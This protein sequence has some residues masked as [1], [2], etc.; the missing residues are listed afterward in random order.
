VR[1]YFTLIALPVMILCLSGLSAFA[2]RAQDVEWCNGK[3]DASPDLQIGACTAL[4]QSGKGNRKALVMWFNNRGL[5]FLKK[6]NFDAAIADLEQSL[7][8]EPDNVIAYA[9]RAYLYCSRKD[10]DKCISDNTKVISLYAPG[11]P[12]D[13]KKQAPYY[14]SRAEAYEA[15]GN[16]DLALSDL[17]E[18]IK[19][20]STYAGYFFHRGNIFQEKSDYDHAIADFTDAIRLDPKYTGA[21]GYRA[22][23][24]LAKGDYAQAIADSSEAI[25]VAPIYAIA[26][27]TRCWARAIL[28]QL[29]DALKDCNEALDDSSNFFGAFDSR[30]LVY[31]KLGEL[32]KSIT[33]YNSALSINPKFASSLY[34]RGLAKNKKQSGSGDADIAAAVELS[35]DIA[36]DYDSYGIK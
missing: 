9:T 1:S 12:A 23:A 3:G 24:Y 32:D 30:A 11:P 6:S 7:R 22:I 33:D 15:T 4:I 16:L 36:K 18:A 10:Y 27:N 26:W 5:A 14:E 35:P 8:I 28:G 2:Q 31:L 13:R 29:Q 17:N 20:D 34:G 21:F 19:L 25:R